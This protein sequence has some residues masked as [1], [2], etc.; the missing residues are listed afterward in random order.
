MGT[1]YFTLENVESIQNEPPHV[2]VWRDVTDPDL[3]VPFCRCVLTTAS[4]DM[5]VMAT[6][7]R[8]STRKV[9]SNR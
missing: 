6:T 8:V 1:H 5:T 7:A 3:C 2:W 4:D 9:A